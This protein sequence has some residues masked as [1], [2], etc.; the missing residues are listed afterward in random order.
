MGEKYEKG[1]GQEENVKETVCKYYFGWGEGGGWDIVFGLIYRP[2]KRREQVV[3]GKEIVD[4][5]KKYM[6]QLWE[7]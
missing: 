3:E 5:V 1:E 4:K 6:D 2:M 7:I